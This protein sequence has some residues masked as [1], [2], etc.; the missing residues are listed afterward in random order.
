MGGVDWVHSRARFLALEKS[1]GRQ[2][3][4][5]SQKITVSANNPMADTVEPTV[6][7]LC[8]KLIVSG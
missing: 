3:I 1:A 7:M 5:A 8:H 4:K 6:E 2:F